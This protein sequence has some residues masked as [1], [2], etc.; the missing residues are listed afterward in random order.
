MIQIYYSPQ[1][2]AAVIIKD[3]D[4]NCRQ[5]N[6]EHSLAKITSGLQVMQR[7]AQWC[8]SRVWLDMHVYCL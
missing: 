1:S 5:E 4:H 7:A 3:G 2:T 6:T 8:G